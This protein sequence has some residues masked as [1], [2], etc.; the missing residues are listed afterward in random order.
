MIATAQEF[1]PGVRIVVWDLGLRDEQGLKVSGAIFLSPT[2]E[3]TLREVMFSVMSV[4]LFKNR[5]VACD[6]Y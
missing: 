6:H 2:N 3:V 1:A 4:T 5:S